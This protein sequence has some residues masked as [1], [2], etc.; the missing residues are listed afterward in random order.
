MPSPRRH[1]YAHLYRRLALLRRKSLARLPQHRPPHLIKSGTAKWLFF[2]SLSPR[3]R[4]V[5]TAEDAARPSPQ[6]RQIK[7]HEK[8]RPFRRTY[9]HR[10]VIRS[11]RRSREFHAKR[12]A[13]QIASIVAAPVIRLAAKAR[14]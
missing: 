10:R 3:I 8:L 11:K 9:L 12:R 7:I 2:D 1:H 4:F 6:R 14:R 13:R 5:I